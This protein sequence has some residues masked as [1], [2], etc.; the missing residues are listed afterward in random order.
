MIALAYH[1]AS[2]L[3]YV[4][5]IG[6]A[7]ARQERSA[8]FTL[9]HGADEGFRRFRRVAAAL[10]YNDA[11][12]FVWLCIATRHTLRLDVPPSITVIVGALLVLVGLAVKFWAAASLGAGAYYWRDFFL[13]AERSAPAGGPY[14]FLKNPMYTV[15]YL[16]AYGC[17]LVA[18]SLPG[19]IAAALDQAA[20]LA[21]YRWVE[22]PHVE[23]M[24]TS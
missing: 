19:L 22:K 4:L 7:L 18:A 13:P 23:K 24:L 3:A 1:L 20:I 6:V 14:P 5:Y 8:S 10:M 12:S 16:P 11:A 17:A 9:Q 2:R 21:F 15:G